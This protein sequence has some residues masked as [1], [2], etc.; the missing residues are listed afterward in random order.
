M[1]QAKIGY[2]KNHLSKYVDHVREGGEVVIYDRET[3]VARMVPLAPFSS[4]GADQDRLARLE[5]KGLIRRGQQPAQPAA[6]RRDRP[7]AGAPPK[8]R[9]LVAVP[10]SVLADLLAER[11]TSL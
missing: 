8:G 1:K 11:G 2:L 6:T 7:S 3:A 5:R 9:A 4:A 10:G